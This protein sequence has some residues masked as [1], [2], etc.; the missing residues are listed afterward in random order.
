MVRIICILVGLF[1]AMGLQSQTISTIPKP[2]NPSAQKGNF[3]IDRATSIHYQKQ[4]KAGKNAAQFL[5]HALAE[6]AG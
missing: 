2:V 5:N 6:I 3:I 4:N 1:I